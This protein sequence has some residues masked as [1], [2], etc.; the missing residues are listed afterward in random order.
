M[1]FRP[2]QTG[3]CCGKAIR[4]DNDQ[5]DK[6]RLDEAH[7]SKDL[8]MDHTRIATGEDQDENIVSTAIM[9]LTN[10]DEWGEGEVGLIPG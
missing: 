2:S 5:A 10:M 9:I 6:R 8:A 1:Y 7:V 3:D 4:Q